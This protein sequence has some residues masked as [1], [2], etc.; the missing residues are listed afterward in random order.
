MC[1]QREAKFGVILGSTHAKKMGSRKGAEN[2]EG[3]TRRR[4]VARRRRERRGFVAKKKKR[5]HT[6]STE[7]NGKRDS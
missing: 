5:F 6:K 7:F 4:G 2:A 1:S 3:V